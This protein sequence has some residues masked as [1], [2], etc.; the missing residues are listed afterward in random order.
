MHFAL[1][2][3]MR[4]LLFFSFIFIAPFIKGQDSIFLNEKPIGIVD[5]LLSGG[6]ESIGALKLQDLK[7]QMEIVQYDYIQGDIPTFAG[8]RES[9]YYTIPGQVYLK[10]VYPENHESALE[11]LTLHESLGSLYYQDENYALSI[12]LKML[13]DK[14]AEER[15]DLLQHPNVQFMFSKEPMYMNSTGGGATAVG[16]GGDFMAAWIKYRVSQ[17]VLKYNHT[18]LTIYF[19]SQL[20]FEPQTQKK[21]SQSILIEPEDYKIPHQGLLDFT[22]NEHA[23]DP[24]RRHN[25]SLDFKI[26]IPTKWFEQNPNFIEPA[27]QEISNFYRLFAQTLDR[28]AKPKI[29]IIAKCGYV[30]LILPSKLLENDLLLRSGGL[31]PFIENFRIGCL[32]DFGFETQILKY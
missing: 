32:N 20:R 4:A 25:L 3:L 13:A 9:A 19:L 8:D 12:I 14:P 30:Q 11:L 23:K 28:T 21:T 10:E 29:K 24:E 7:K 5:N 27:V 6:I 22:K 15:Q 1:I 16:G 2:N 18:V 31:D 26:L 17:E